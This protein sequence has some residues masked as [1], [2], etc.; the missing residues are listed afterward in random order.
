MTALQE[1]RWHLAT[2]FLFARHHH[3]RWPFSYR[4]ILYHSLRADSKRQ[5]NTLA[6]AFITLLFL[7][8]DVKELGFQLSYL[9]VLGLLVVAPSLRF[10]KPK[11][12]APGAGSSALVWRWFKG[13][14][15]ASFAVGLC[16]WP[17]LAATVH[18]VSPSMFVTN[19]LATP[20]MF[21]LLVL[22]LLTP[23]T[24]L[25]GLNVAIPYALSML[26]GL[27]DYI[28]SFFATVPYGHLFLAAPPI[29]W[30]CAYYLALFF[31][32]LLPRISLPSALAP[33]TWL[34]VIALLPAMSLAQTEAPGPLRFTMLDVG[35]GQC[36]VAE[37]PTGPCIVFDCGSTSVGGIGERVLA[38]YLWERGRDRIDAVFISHADADHVNGLPQL[39]E[40][41]DVGMFVVAE[42]LGRDPVGHELEEWLSRYATVKVLKRGQ[43]IE[44]T[45]DIRVRCLWPDTEFVDSLIS[46]RD[47]RNEGGFVLVLEAGESRVVVPAD[48]ESAVW[49]HGARRGNQLLVAPHQGSR[50]SGL[51]SILEQLQPEHIVISARST[52]PPGDVIKEYD[53]YTNTYKTWESGAVTAEVWSDG[54]IEI[55][56]FRD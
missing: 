17:L 48:V 25:P 47:W 13:S 5:R 35:Q 34:I 53:A 51:K 1:N 39:V 38:P 32:F 21:L 37:I 40:R 41:F 43:T 9:A 29:W 50:V 42:T 45:K 12:L 23:M 24:V 22:G 31:I 8:S 7:P 26:T 52:F 2:G 44:L 49:T 30:L 11:S 27:L 18:V 10:M 46:K 16:T 4:R 6:A 15:R 33:A 36:A 54:R 3:K 28:A 19:L 55:D 14:V 20:I 56:T